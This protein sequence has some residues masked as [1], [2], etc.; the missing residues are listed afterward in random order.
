MSRWSDPTPPQ[1]LAA[2]CTRDPAEL[3]RHAQDAALGIPAP[4]DFTLVR[5]RDL[6]DVVA[7]LEWAA[8]ERLPV[9]PQGA[10]TGLAGGAVPL[11][12]G[13]ALNLEAMDA[14][15]DVDP[16]EALAVVQAGVITSELKSAAS[17]AGL[18]YG[19]D[20][21]SVAIS[22]VGGNVATNAGGLCCLKY[23]DTAASV[24]ALEVVLPGGE[25]M[26]TGH[27]TA[28]GV[29]GLD[30]TGLFVGSEGQLGVVTRVWASLGPQPEQPAT[31]L[32]T[33]PTLRAGCDAIVA[34]RRERHRPS[35][36][37]LMDGPTVAAVQAY[38]DYGFPEGVQ[39]AL[40]VQSDR[41]GHTAEDAARYAEV[42]SA[43]GATTVE[44][45]TTPEASHTLMAGR[46]AISHALDRLGHNL[47]EDMCVPVQALA[48][49]IER[50]YEIGEQHGTRIVTA[51]HGGD[52]N[53]HPTVYF[54]PADPDQTR[55]AH[56]AITALV[57]VTLELGGTITGEH[58]VGILKSD[59][60]ATELGAAEIER[61]RGLKHFFDPLGI[62]NPGRVL[63]PTA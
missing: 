27:R 9:V 63:W 37:E 23:G 56:D 58:G 53:M 2:A 10:R 39:A 62:M 13:I 1:A 25:V 44:V 50:G 54:D 41:A 4:E 20:P 18:H 34:L 47:T 51:G 8:A 3:A 36:L 29:A 7:A 22:T 19:P 38:G 26:R 21:A 17:D 49:F 31:V 40:L 32:A 60:L 43:A 30:L 52:G 45:A 5:A 12:G 6:D 35:L 15:E 57:A 61:Q 48:E 55:R 42:C 24:R 14:I 28:K 33:F 59:W 46:R 16:V 11:E